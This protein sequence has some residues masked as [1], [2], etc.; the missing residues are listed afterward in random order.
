M[1]WL[2]LLWVVGGFAALGALG[3]LFEKL[4]EWRAK[5]RER[6][7]LIHKEV[8]TPWIAEVTRGTY[9]VSRGTY[10]YRT[11]EDAREA[12]NQMRAETDPV[13]GASEGR[14]YR[15][16]AGYKVLVDEFRK[17]RHWEGWDYEAVERHAEWV[18][19]LN[20]MTA[21]ERDEFMRSAREKSQGDESD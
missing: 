17:D 3:T 15:L 19:K 18:R 11:E 13:R 12:M 7:E 5:K 14:L 8:D 6:I 16:N 21:D 20:N 10:H 1:D 9:M 4:S 2:A